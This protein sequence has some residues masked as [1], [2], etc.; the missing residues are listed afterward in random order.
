MRDPL[1]AN[2]E[3]PGTAGEK[4]VLFRSD[5]KEKDKSN[6]G[7]YA[8]GT[9]VQHPWTRPPRPLWRQRRRCLLRWAAPSAVDR[10]LSRLLAR[11][12]SHVL[13]CRRVAEQLMHLR[14]VLRE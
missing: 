6:E 2:E 4:R 3:L 7:T 11:T 8:V 5:T 1:H 9:P 13:R 14:R 10:V 12:R